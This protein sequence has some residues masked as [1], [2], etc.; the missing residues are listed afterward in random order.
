MSADKSATAS[1]SAAVRVLI[2]GT[3]LA[4]LS[5]CSTF[6][7]T[8]PPVVTQSDA[9]TNG[10]AP[11]TP[12]ASAPA[13]VADIKPDAPSG[14]VDQLNQ[15]IQSHKVSEMRTAYNGTYGASL[16][17]KPDD[18][19]YYAVLFQQKDFWRVVH[20]P[21][22]SQAE[23]AFRAFTDQS[24]QLA[25]VDL[26][27]IKLQAEYDRSQQ[28]LDA[29]NQALSSLQADQAVRERQDKQ[30]AALQAQSRDEANQLAGQQNDARR[31]LRKLQRQIDRLKAQ[32]DDVDVVLPAVPAKVVA[33]APAKPKTRHMRESSRKSV[34]HAEKKASHE[35]QAVQK[36]Q[37]QQ[38]IDPL[39]TA[40]PPASS[41]QTPAK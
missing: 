39:P 21:S 6:M 23:A 35:K 22:Q 27:R 29:R 14:T 34:H 38:V 25:A 12:P 10:A 5:A 17:F 2:A 33:K 40:P 3:V 7:H 28:L 20:T 19:T 24:A 41:A 15:L 36:S 31:E 32:Q 9:P 13:P 4:G 8:T 18:L 1:V 26:Q 37:P 30:V 16:L 11:V